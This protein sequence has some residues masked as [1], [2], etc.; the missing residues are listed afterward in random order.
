M[1]QTI[2]AE[3]ISTGSELMLGRMVD[4]NSAWLSEFLGGLGIPTVRHTSVGDDFERLVEVFKRGWEDSRLTVVTGGLGPTEDDLT[5]QAAAAAFGLELEFRQ[6]LA[7]EIRAMFQSR[8]AVMTNNNLRQAWLPRGGR[9]VPNPTGTAPGFAL[10]DEE[11]LMVFLPGV[12]REMKIMC[13]SWLKPHLKE[14]FP[15]LNAQRHTVVL[16]TAGLGESLVDNM[17]GDLMVPD[18]NPTIGLLAG[19]DMVNVLVTATGRDLDEA[20]ALAGPVVAE[21]EKR[22]HGHVFGYGD[23]SLAEVVAGLLKERDLSLTIL[24]AVTQGRLNGRLAPSLELENWSGGQDL[25]WQPT[26]SGIM[27][28]LRLYA[29]DSLALRFDEDDPGP[30]RRRYGREI[31]LIITAQVDREAAPPA[32]GHLALVMESG[33][34]SETIGDGRAMVRKF[35]LGGQRNWALSRAAALSMFHLWQV[36]KGYSASD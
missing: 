23:D 32:P 13:D 26:L 30:R 21:L 2:S 11:R 3:I 31:R 10:A 15:G 8:G 36:L 12:P 34:Q 1:E 17:I 6:E 29:P 25:P 28:I 22:L 16:R 18:G 20:R 35:R 24:D 27:E 5:R 7:E 4:T 19:P 14:Q 9:P 33:V